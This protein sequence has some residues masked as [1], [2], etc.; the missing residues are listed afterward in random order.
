MGIFDKLF[1]E[2]EIKAILG[3]LNELDFEMAE[4]PHFDDVRSLAEKIILKNKHDIIRTMKEQ[5]ISPRRTACSWINNVSGDFLES[6][7]YHVYRGVL[8]P[9]GNAYLKIFDRSTGLLSQVG[10]MSEEEA[11]EHKQNIRNRIQE[12]G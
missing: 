3:V 7:Q 4:F 2:K 10:D 6:G 5:N 12:V 11:K 1:L 8:S 9:V